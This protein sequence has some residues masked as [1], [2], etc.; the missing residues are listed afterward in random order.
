MECILLKQNE[1]LEVESWHDSQRFTIIYKPKRDIIINIKKKN[2]KYRSLDEYNMNYLCKSFDLLKQ[3]IID[4]IGLDLA[5]YNDI[6][7]SSK[8][9]H[10]TRLNND[11]EFLGYK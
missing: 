5:F 4:D 9:K 7:T 6:D 11:F 3:W 8:G 10:K 1:I 2:G